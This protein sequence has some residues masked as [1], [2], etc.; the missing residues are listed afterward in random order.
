MSRRRDIAETERPRLT[1]SPSCAAV[2]PATANS[3]ETLRSRVS[4]Q[5]A[6]TTDHRRRFASCDASSAPFS[7]FKLP[8]GADP[9]VRARPGFSRRPSGEV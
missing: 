7:G 9:A 2:T 6:R 8:H 4:L 3:R 1:P 5:P